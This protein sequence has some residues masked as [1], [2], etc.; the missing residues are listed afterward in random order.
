MNLGN[1]LTDISIIA[2]SHYGHDTVKFV[3]IKYST[4]GNFFTAK[5]KMNGENSIYE[6]GKTPEEAAKKLKKRL[7]KI[8]KRYLI[9]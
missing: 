9:V 2:E 6:N 7:L 4:A 8:I 1:T 3:G 5:L